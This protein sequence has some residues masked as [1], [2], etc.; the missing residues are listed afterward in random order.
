MISKA[1]LRFL[2][3]LLRDPKFRYQENLF[4]IEGFNLVKAA[5]VTNRL[6][7]I[8]YLKDDSKAIGLLENLTNGINC[9]ELN[10]DSLRLI[11]STKTPQG[12]VGLCEI[13][14]SS[15]EKFLSAD[16]IWILDQVADPGNAGT[17]MRAL[18]LFD[19][20][21]PYLMFL[22]TVDP[23]NPKVLRASS[24]AIFDCE[25]YLSD[26]LSP[27]KALKDNGFRLYS[28]V[29][30]GGKDVSSCQFEKKTAVVLGNET[31][32]VSYLKDLFDEAI[33]IPTAQ[34]AIDSLN[35]SMAATIIAY[36][37]LTKRKFV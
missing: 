18:S 8:Y 2:R 25:L 36:I 32:G 14:L 22:N 37:R 3:K 27:I 35:V 11:T 31:R 34:K 19:E 15:L 13:K 9:Y 21:R 6:K 5:L 23:F 12:L 26:D 28:T 4:V 1:Q 29:V 10:E 30:K 16:F 24:G 20:K 17:I 7:S 33:T